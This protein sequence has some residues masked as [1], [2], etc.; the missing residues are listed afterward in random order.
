VTE[1]KQETGRYE[2]TNWWMGVKGGAMDWS[3][4]WRAV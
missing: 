2:A 4:I 3:P 1:N